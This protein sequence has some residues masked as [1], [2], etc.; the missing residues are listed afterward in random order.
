M[1]IDIRNNRGDITASI[2]VINDKI[3]EKT[4]KGCYVSDID[5]NDDGS[6]CYRVDVITP[7]EFI[8]RLSTKQILEELQ[9]RL[10]Q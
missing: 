6:D 4:L 1:T 5:G 8:E 3:V 10:I 7:E 2:E 9:G